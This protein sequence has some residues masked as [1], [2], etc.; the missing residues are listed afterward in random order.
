M[1]ILNAGTKFILGCG[2]ALALVVPLHRARAETMLYSFKG[3][4]KDGANPESGGGGLIK[5]S[6]GNLYGT[7]YAG[8]ASGF[9]IVFKLARSGT[10]TVLYSFAG[11][12]N[13]GSFPYAGL[14]RDGAGNFYGT[15]S[16][17]GAYDGGTV[18]KL[19]PDGTETVL[20]SFNGGNDGRLP[21][22]GLIQDKKGNFYG[23]T[24]GGGPSDA[25]TVFKL[26]PDGVERVLYSFCS[27]PDCSDG[28]APFAGLIKDTSGNLYGTTAYSAANDSRCGTVFKLAPDGT[29]TVLHPFT[30]RDGC[31]PIGGLIKDS[32]G[33]LYGTTDTGGAFGLGTVFRLAPGGTETVLH[34]FRGGNDGSNPTAG[35]IEDRAGNLYGTTAYGAGTGCSSGTG[36]GTV[37]K[38]AP[39]GT[40]TVLHSFEGPSDDGNTRVAGLINDKKG[41]LYGTTLSGG[42]GNGCSGGCGTVFRLKE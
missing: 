23:T 30:G 29:E 36:C 37:F 9:G 4:S 39:G 14:I 18:F 34:S 38:L 17:G 16:Q 10:E 27:R 42:E 35:L 41:H 1:R 8:G 28:F 31:I 20:H 22:A 24:Y 6:E 32:S 15:T 7:A 33:N 26:A 40:E 3:G 21:V 11:N 2:L 5:D 13:D 12:A 25:G 19:A